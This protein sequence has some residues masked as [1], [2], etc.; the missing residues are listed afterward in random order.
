MKCALPGR[1]DKKVSIESSAIL[2]SYYDTDIDGEKQLAEDI[3]LSFDEACKAFEHLNRDFY[4]ELEKYQIGEV[5]EYKNKDI[6]E[7][8]IK[9]KQE[10][11][12]KDKEKH[13]Q[14]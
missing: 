11:L 1:Y 9:I 7:Q 10:L 8:M 13:S 4:K 6:S 3:G 2:D 5:K 14:K 12:R